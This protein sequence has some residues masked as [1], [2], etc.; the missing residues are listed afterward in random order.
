MNQDLAIFTT[1]GVVFLIFVVF[2]G[3]LWLLDR[4][5]MYMGRNCCFVLFMLLA[6]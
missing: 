3:V 1:W 5:K 6:Y 4:R 2:A